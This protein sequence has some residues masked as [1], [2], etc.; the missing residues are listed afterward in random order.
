MAIKLV[1]CNKQFGIFFKF[2]DEY[3]CNIH[4]EEHWSVLVSSVIVIWEDI[5]NLEAFF[6]EITNIQVKLCLS[7]LGVHAWA[8]DICVNFNCCGPAGQLNKKH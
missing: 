6:S 2:Q 3:L 8:H 7:T 4:I 5:G 1:I